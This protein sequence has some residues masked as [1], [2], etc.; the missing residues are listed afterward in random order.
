THLKMDGSWRISPATRSP[1]GDYRVRLILANREWQAVGGLLGIVEVIRTSREDAA[2]GHLGPGLLG[3][4][5]A[6]GEAGRR[7]PAEPGPPVGEALLEQRSLAGIGTICRAETLFL[8]GVSP[9]RPVGEIADLHGLVELARRLLEANKDRAG[10]V[11]TGDRARGA[12]MWVYGR[13]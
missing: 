2:L 6:V 11:T 5:V 8:R 7:L 3:P 10:T 13:A 12:A 4:E 1:R 9:W